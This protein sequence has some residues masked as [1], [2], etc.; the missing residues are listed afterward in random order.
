MGRRWARVP[1]LSHHR[2]GFSPPQS[3]GLGAG[4]GPASAHRLVGRGRRPCQS[5]WAAHEGPGAPSDHPSWGGQPA[6]GARNNARLPCFFPGRAAWSAARPR[7]PPLHQ[8]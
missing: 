8:Q 2:P 7:N 3:G 5:R 1:S 4:L 6:G